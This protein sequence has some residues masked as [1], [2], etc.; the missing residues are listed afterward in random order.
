[1]KKARKNRG[2]KISAKILCFR[3]SITLSDSNGIISA[4]Y[5]THDGLFNYGNYIAFCT[6]SQLFFD[7]KYDIIMFP[8]DKRE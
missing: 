2:R 5:G 7:K 6:E 3:S 8:R 1:M 4:D